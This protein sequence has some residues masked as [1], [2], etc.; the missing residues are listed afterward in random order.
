M[1]FGEHLEELR[2]R[3]AFG[4]IAFAVAFA[5]AFAFQ[6][7]LMGIFERPYER[8]RQSLNADYARDW[9]SQPHPEVGERRAVDLLIEMLKQKGSLTDEEVARLAALQ[10]QER[11]EGPPQ[12][13]KLTAISAGEPIAAYMMVC[14]LSAALV[15]APVLLAQLWKFVGAGLY[16]HERRMVLRVLPF[17]L[18]LFFLGLAFG[19]F[20]LSELSVR[21]L[22]GYGGLEYVRPNVTIGSYLGLLFMLLLVMGLVFQIPLVMTVLAAVGIASP[23]FF[24]KYRRH[25]LLAIF[26]VAAIITPPDYISQLLVAAPMIVLFELGIWLS[27]GAAKR[28]A[29]KQAG[30]G[31]GGAPKPPAAPPPSP[32]PATPPPQM[33]A[34]T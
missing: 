21:F 32:P 6:D 5:A 2:R 18:L 29:E 17:S 1:T 25:S 27:A 7:R 4:L 30:D 15:S 31:G 14:L 11:I 3:L 24:R 9:A 23:Q 8:A 13:D 16:D 12:L 10:K 20:V 22:V 34:T 26:I 33:V 19:Y 28:R